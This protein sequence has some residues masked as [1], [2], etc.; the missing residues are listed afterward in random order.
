MGNQKVTWTSN[1]NTTI[2]AGET[3]KMN[4]DLMNVGNATATGLKAVLI[5]NNAQ[6]SCP[7]A[8]IVYPAI[9]FAETKTNT[10]AFQFQTSA[11]YT[12]M[13][14]LTLQVSNEYG[15]TWNF[16]VNPLSRPAVVNISTINSQAF[17]SS[18]NVYWTSMGDKISYNIYRSD[19]GANGT[20]KKLNKFPLTT[21]YYLD[22]NL[23]G[24]TMFHY[25]VAAVS[26]NGNESEWSV[27]YQTW[28][29][30]PVVSPFPRRIATGT[31]SSVS[32]PNIADVDNDGKQEIFWIYEDRSGTRTS[33]L[34]GFRPTG[35]ELFDIDGNVTTVSGF[36]KT[37]TMLTGQV[38]FGDL[39]GNG[40]QNIVVSTWDDTCLLYTSPSPRD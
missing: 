21:T 30:Y 26:D 8:Q 31:Y 34:M 29:S 12:G 33:Y 22:E 28:T 39:A 9:P 4:I 3:V 20:Y 32:S 5:S 27:A 15:K 10:A 16:P 40:E 11:S 25:K 36:A 37:P 1:G 13:L 24:C 7:S 17:S 19:N 38:A 2:E 23:P 6:V 14:N 18:I 35:E